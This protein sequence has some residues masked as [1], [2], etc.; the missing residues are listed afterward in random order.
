MWTS[1]RQSTSISLIRYSIGIWKHTLY[2]AEIHY[3]IVHHSCLQIPS[4]H[5]MC[6]WLGCFRFPKIILPF[7]N[8]IRLNLRWSL[9]FQWSNCYMQT[10]LGGQTHFISLLIHF[11]KCQFFM[12][13]W[14]PH[15][16]PRHLMFTLPISWM[17]GDAILIMYISTYSWLHDYLLQWINFKEWHR[18][19]DQQIMKK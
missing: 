17:F 1:H 13:I 7:T 12:H 3:Y 5:L 2:M 11:W 9:V 18:L 15:P 14:F 19:G 6:D 10:S 4:T 8:Q 16:I